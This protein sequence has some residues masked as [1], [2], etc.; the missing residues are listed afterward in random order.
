MLNNTD[1][2]QDKTQ[3][4]TITSLEIQLQNYL[5]SLSEKEKQTLEIAKDHLQTSF[6]LEKSIGFLEWLKSNNN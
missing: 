3:D 4:K 2:I 1:K 5:D 6:C